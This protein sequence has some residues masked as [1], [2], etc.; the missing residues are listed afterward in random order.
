MTIEPRGSP[1]AL[2]AIARRDNQPSLMPLIPI[3]LGT[4]FMLGV[5][6]KPI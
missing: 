6:I 1:R 2:G 3:I 5:V 4:L